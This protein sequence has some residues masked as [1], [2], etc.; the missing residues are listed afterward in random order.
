ME[1]FGG[2]Q[3]VLSYLQE[4]EGRA[5][6][7]LGKR[8]QIVDLDIKRNQNR[9]ALRSLSKD[10]SPADQEQLDKEISGLRRELKVK[11]KE[12]YEAQG[13]PELK[14][15]DLVALSTEEMKSIQKA[16]GE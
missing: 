3:R 13:K 11:V 16:L 2:P 4:V 9:E 1:Q 7:V 12:L 10:P 5:E 14:G 15:F 6:D 8:R